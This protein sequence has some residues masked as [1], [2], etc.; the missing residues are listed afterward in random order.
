MIPIIQLLNRIRWDRTF[1]DADFIIGYY[2]RVADDI[3]RVPFSSLIMEAGNHFAVLIFNE[4]SIL[5]TVPL[6]R[7]REVYRNGELIWCR[8]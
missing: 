3:I 8:P 2:D 5:H 7:I 4:D 6:H 1:G